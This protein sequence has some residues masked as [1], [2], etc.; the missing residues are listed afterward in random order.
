MKL[1]ILSENTSLRSDLKAEYGLSMLL[2]KGNTKLL[3]D[4][5]SY[6]AFMENAEVMGIDLKNITA[7]AFSHNHVDH[8]GGLIFF[9]EQ[10]KHALPIYIRTDFFRNKYWD[11]SQDLPET[12]TYGDFLEHVGPPFDWSFIHKSRLTGVR[13]LAG[14]VFPL[15]DD[16]Y[17]VGNF[18][19]PTDNESV[20]PTS[21]ME[22][23]DGSCI[24]DEFTEEQVCVVRTKNGLVVLTGCAHHGIRNILTTIEKRFPGEPIRAVFGGTHLLP[25][26]MERIEETAEFLTTHVQGTCGVCHCTGEVGLAVMTEK[27]SS[28]VKTGAGYI[29]ECED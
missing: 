25:P 11:H 6:Q 16:V 27:V 7:A 19:V 3:F 20:H 17:L 1:T 21:V 4:M 28:Y 22:T 15:G 29:Y 23:A 12:T 9:A 10:M 14:D 8:A 5:G 24:R 26:S 18:P 13:V 2:E